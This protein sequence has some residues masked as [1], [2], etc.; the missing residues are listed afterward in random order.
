[1]AEQEKEFLKVLKLLSDNDV[2]GHVIV[3]GSWAE[4]LYQ[5]TGL[6]PSGTTALRTLD[7]DFLVKNMKLPQPPVNFERAAREAGYAVENDFV[8]GTTKI[9]TASRLEI[10]FLIDQKGAGAEH[11]Y[12]T[13]IGVTA[14]A[15]RGLNLLLKHT[16]EIE[17][18]GIKV[19]VPLPEV[20]VLHKII[21]NADRNK[22]Y[23]REKDRGNILALFPHLDMAT[24][25]SILGEATKKQRD[26]VHSFYEANPELAS[27]YTLT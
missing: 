7:I 18:L 22:D 1:M 14:Q 9:M 13:A 23:K 27:M 4:Y 10:E 25:N 24:Y 6:I 2:L 3:I 12:R 5:N 19:T 8:L 26:K 11:V 17:Y 20:Y 21:I 16:A 15:L